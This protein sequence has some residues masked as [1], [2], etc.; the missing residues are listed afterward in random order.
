MSALC[1]SEML[2]QRFDAAALS[3]LARKQSAVPLRRAG[4]LTELAIIGV[5]ACL[6]GKPDRSTI[7]LWGS[8]TG[9]REAGIRVVADVVIARESPFPFDFLA[10]Q[11][12][13]AA[14][15]LQ[16]SFPCIESAL[17]QPWAGNAELCWQ[18]MRT[19]AAIF[20]QAGRHVR[21][22]CGQVEPGENEHIGRWQVL[23]D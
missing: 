17:Y 13:L 19:L 12:I 4:A 8:S 5:A 11:P 20:L 18:R 10:T 3:A 22:L 23:E 9:A 7:V 14:P 21:A 15:L 6:A 16:R 2:E 1:I